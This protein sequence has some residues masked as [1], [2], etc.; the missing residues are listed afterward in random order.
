MHSWFRV[1]QGCGGSLH[2]DFGASS[3]GFLSL[4]FLFLTGWLCWQLQSL[5]IK[6]AAFCLS[7]ILCLCPF[8]FLPTFGG[9]SVFLSTAVFFNVLSRVIIVSVRKIS[10]IQSIMPYLV[11]EFL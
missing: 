9:S 5:S 4:I 1:S 6:T 7:S 2:I 3:S 8:L 10:L 11:P